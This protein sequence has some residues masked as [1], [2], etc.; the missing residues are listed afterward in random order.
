MHLSAPSK[1]GLA[2]FTVEGLY[3]QSSLSR[4]YINGIGFYDIL[5]I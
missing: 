3:L 2:N 1:Q 4:A 5:A